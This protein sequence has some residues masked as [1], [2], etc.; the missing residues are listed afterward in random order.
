MIPRWGV[1]SPV[2]FCVI[3]PGFIVASL[4]SVLIVGPL[5]AEAAQYFQDLDLG[6]LLARTCCCL[7]EPQTPRV[8]AGT[9]SKA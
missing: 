7:H 9:R 4:F 3:Y 8:F 1:F 6:A 5:G 2:A